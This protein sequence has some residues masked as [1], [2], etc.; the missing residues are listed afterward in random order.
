MR[1][2]HELV[3]QFPQVNH[4]DEIPGASDLKLVG[5]LDFV[6]DT[7][8][9]L[10]PFPSG[11]R[12]IEYFGKI[13]IKIRFPDN[14][15]IA[16]VVFLPYIPVIESGQWAAMHA[17]RFYRGKFSQLGQVFLESL[18]SLV[19]VAIKEIQVFIMIADFMP[20]LAYLL[21]NFSVVRFGDN[22]E[23]I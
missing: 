17:Y 1:V 21:D 9:I 10:I 12:D 5:G 2:N 20:D 13:Q 19:E 6:S 23:V 7:G 4:L 8:F 15:I 11:I 22:S 14:S 18:V 3:R 16:I